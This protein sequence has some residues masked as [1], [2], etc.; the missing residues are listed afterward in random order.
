MAFQHKY[1]TMLCL[2]TPKYEQRPSSPFISCSIYKGMC[3]P[4]CVAQFASSCDILGDLNG[5]LIMENTNVILFMFIY[6]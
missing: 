2:E 5:I 4:M 3:V 6:I 1:V